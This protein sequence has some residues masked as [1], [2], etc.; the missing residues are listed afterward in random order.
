MKL[1]K[2]PL[3]PNC[4]IGFR[5]SPLPQSRS[6]WIPASALLNGFF[7]TTGHLD[8]FYWTENRMFINFWKTDHFPGEIPP[9]IR[10]RIGRSRYV[11]TIYPVPPKLSVVVIKYHGVGSYQCDLLKEGRWILRTMTKI[12]PQ[13]VNSH[14]SLTQAVVWFANISKA[15]ERGHTWKGKIASRRI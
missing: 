9:N 7:K 4:S 12:R 1:L 10:G 11:M 2:F 3:P 14:R 15:S 5:E 13:G 6:R 8:L